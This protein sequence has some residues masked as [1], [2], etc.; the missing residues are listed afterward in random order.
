MMSPQEIVLIGV[1]NNLIQVIAAYI[2]DKYRFIAINRNFDV[3]Q[4]QTYS[5]IILFIVDT[6]CVYLDVE[7]LINQIKS[8]T[9]YQNIPAIGLSFKQH[10]AQMSA[11]FR[12]KFEDFLLKPMGNED[13]LTRIEVWVRTFEIVNSEEVQAK[14]YSLDTLS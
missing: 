9:E 7:E 11:S 1:E 8:K 6:D 2:G 5:N 13:L 12:N 3:T 4:L 14:T 10:F